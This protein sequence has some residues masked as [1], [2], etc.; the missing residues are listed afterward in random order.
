MPKRS[1]SPPPPQQVGG[2]RPAKL[3]TIHQLKATDRPTDVEVMLLRRARDLF[4]KLKDTSDGALSLPEAME[5]DA[6]QLIE[7]IFSCSSTIDAWMRDVTATATQIVGKY[8]DL[9]QK[10]ITLQ[11]RYYKLVFLRRMYIFAR[12][13]R[14]TS[15]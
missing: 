3:K 12:T 13:T 10:H 9:Q 6:S 15:E 8:N 2:K 5:G 1:S 4:L 7:D 14:S 11:T